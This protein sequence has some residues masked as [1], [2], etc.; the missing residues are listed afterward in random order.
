L[1][2]PTA[3]IDFVHLRRDAHDGIALRGDDA[4]RMARAAAGAGFDHEIWKCQQSL[5][6]DTRLTLSALV[7]RQVDAA[8]EEH[9]AHLRARRV[10][11]QYD[12]HQR[13]NSP[14]ADSVPDSCATD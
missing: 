6:G 3:E 10:S 1:A 9:A 5:R 8:A 13:K 7:E 14:L 2:G 12:V 11:Y 4:C